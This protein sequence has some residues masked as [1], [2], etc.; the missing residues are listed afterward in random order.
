MSQ[1][2]TLIEVFAEEERTESAKRKNER[3]DRI[4]EAVRRLGKAS[5]AAKELGITSAAVYSACLQA[6]VSVLDITR[7]HRAARNWELAEYAAEFGA[8]ETCRRFG[9]SITAVRNACAES[10]VRAASPGVDTGGSTVRI[11]SLILQGGTN[12]SVAREVGVT[13]QRVSK[14]RQECLKYM[15]ITSSTAPAKSSDEKSC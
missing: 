12:R 13:R 6:G 10:G 7:K 5:L 11:V 14:V 8:P 9:V 2:K 15:I 3:R 4:V 1:G